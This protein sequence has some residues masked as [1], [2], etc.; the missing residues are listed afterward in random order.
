[1]KTGKTFTIALLC[2]SALLSFQSCNLKDDSDNIYSALVTIDSNEAGTT[3]QL[4]DSTV[5]KPTNMKANLYGGKSLRAL[6]DFTVDDVTLLSRKEFEAKIMIV[7]TIRTK[8]PVPDLGE[9]NDREYGKDRIEIVNDWVCIGEDGY[10]TLRLRTMR[11][12]ASK[13]HYV[14]LVRVENEKDGDK[15]YTFELRHDASGDLYGHQ[16]DGLVAFDLNELA[17]EDGSPVTLHLKWAGF[18]EEK[19]ANVKLTFRKK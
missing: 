16:T 8:K 9:L 11:S 7:D 17:P 14:N 10:L 3:L 2:A 4:N 1:M 6:V 12:D 13:K 19:S 15:E 18:L 5:I